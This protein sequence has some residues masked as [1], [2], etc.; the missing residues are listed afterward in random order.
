[1]AQAKGG[2]KAPK[3][4]QQGGDKAPAAIHYEEW[5]MEKKIVNDKNVMMEKLKKLR[6]CVKISDEEAEVLNEGAKSPS[7][8]NPIMYFKPG[9][10][11]KEASED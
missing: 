7:S 4:K 5:R 10:A 8:I 1:M 11:S 6:D 9:K 2:D 3:E